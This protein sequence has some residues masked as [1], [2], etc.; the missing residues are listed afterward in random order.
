MCVSGYFLFPDGWGRETKENK[1]WSD[2]H[3]NLKL[4]R[5]RK[6]KVIY[7]LF[8]GEENPEA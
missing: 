3:P 2:H 6:T 4:E 7:N 1:K 8:E 5:R